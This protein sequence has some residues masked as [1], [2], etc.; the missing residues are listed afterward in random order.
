MPKTIRRAVGPRFAKVENSCNCTALRKA[1]RRVSQLYDEA[2]A[3]CGLRVTQLA[4][5][6]QILRMGTPA[7]GELARAL[8]MDRGALAHN[9][10]PLERDGLIE[11]VADPAD[12]RNRLIALTR[13]GRGKLVGSERAWARAQERF[14]ASFGA[15]EAAALRRALA[16][17]A[18]DGF[19]EGFQ[20]PAAR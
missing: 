16:F 15:K 10:K 17:I 18:S 9:V 11:T 13:A 12:R 6:N 20:R 4:I 8:V 7:M 5:L 19:L 1:S 2:L 3:S 14:E